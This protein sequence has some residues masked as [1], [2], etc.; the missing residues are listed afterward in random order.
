MRGS[1]MAQSS[2][3]KGE[4]AVPVIGR[5]LVPRCATVARWV[6]S[7]KDNRAQPCRNSQ[8]GT[9]STGD[10]WR[11]GLRGAPRTAAPHGGRGRPDGGVRGTRPVPAGGPVIAPTG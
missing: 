6:F 7:R 8:P 10:V 9:I 2:G 5:L 1:G 3:E 4:A 11:R